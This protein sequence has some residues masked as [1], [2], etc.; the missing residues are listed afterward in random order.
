MKAIS[1]ST[2]W[3]G[4]A[5]ACGT[6][7]F[8]VTSQAGKPVKPPPPPPAPAAPTYR[9]VPLGTLGGNSVACSINESGWIAGGAIG[10][11]FVVIPESSPNGHGSITGGGYFNGV[12]Q[13]FVLIPATQP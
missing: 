8:A 11:A 2:H 5:L 1:A 4:L 13:A 9:I 7:T 10:G 3:L 12:F 6:L